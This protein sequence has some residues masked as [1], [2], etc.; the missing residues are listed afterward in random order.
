MSENKNKKFYFW[1]GIFATS[2]ICFQAISSYIR[3]NYIGKN[4][5]VKYLLGVAPNFFP[6][7]GIPAL[8][9]AIILQNKKDEHESKLYRYRNIIALSISTLG[10]TGW[11][12]IQSSSAK[13]VFDLNDIL[14]TFIGSLIFIII[15]LLSM[16]RK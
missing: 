10:L 6:S 12:F 1:F 9:V 8:I 3:P 16:V 4:L 15:C 13:L 11:E 14:W 2:F 7:I 5:Y